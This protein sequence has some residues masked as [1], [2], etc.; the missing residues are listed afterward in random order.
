[1]SFDSKNVGLTRRNLLL[2]VATLGAVSLVPQVRAAAEAT[3]A[4]LKLAGDTERQI[5]I[6]GGIVMSMDRSVGDLAKGDILIRGKKILEVAA[7]I[8]APGATVVDADGMI[9]LPGFVDTHHHQYQSAMRGIVT[10]GLVLD[11]PDMKASYRL[12]QTLFN[13]ALQ[14]DDLYI[15]E[16]VGSLNQINAGVTTT[17]DTSQVNNSPEHSDAMIEGLMAAGHRAVFAY[18]SGAGP[19]SL[20]PRDITRIRDQYFPSKD[21]LL[22]L[23]LSTLPIADNYRFGRSIGVPIASHVFHATGRYSLANVMGQDLLTPETLY[24]HCTG[25]P[26]EHWKEIAE[27]GG[28]VSIAPAIEMQMGHGLPPFDEVLRRGITFGL[29]VDEEANMAADFFT[30]MRSA[31][32]FQR[33]MVNER[34]LRQEA[35]VPPLLSAYDTLRIATIEGAKALWLDQEVGSLTPGKEADIVLLSTREINAF[36]LNNV[37]GAVVTLMDTTNVDTVFIA[38]KVRKWRGALV[39]VDLADLRNKIQKSRDGL[40]A[41][42]NYTP[43]LFG[44]CC[45]EVSALPSL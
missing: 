12:I 26:E 1:M 7:S 15:A 29:S 44:S 38:G 11:A 8:D 4:Q 39:D 21:Q 31:Y 18:S 27:T 23:A 20:Y 28:K 13:P 6:K 2:G 10:D 45:Q 9:V 43:D 5:L 42:T 24:I 22:T 25:L 30:I 14:P 36:P 33:A 34:R 17:L 41:R 3:L 35:A 16:L 32:T 37:P 40:L 19:K